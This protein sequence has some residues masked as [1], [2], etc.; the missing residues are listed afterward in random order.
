MG[1]GAWEKMSVEELEAEV[2]RHNRLYF[3]KHVREI[4]DYEF[5]RLVEELK[6]R[7]PDSPVLKEI[8][9]DV[10]EIKGQL[11]L[12]S[13]TKIP[14]S[15]RHEQPMLSLD[16]CYDEN[17]I[18]DWVS[19]IL[20]SIIASPKIDGCAVS[21]KYDEDG[22]LVQAV[23]RGDGVE[24]EDI[25]ENIKEISSIPK[26]VNMKNVEVRG[27]VYMPLSV[28][29]RYQQ[30]FA[31]P[32][33]LAAG[34]IK[35]KDPKK[36]G[37]YKLKFLAY[38]LLRTK[39]QT[40]I[41][42]RKALTNNKFHVVDTVLINSDELQ[43]AYED[44]LNKRNKNDFETDGVVF[45]ANHVSEQTRLGSTAH[46]PKWAIAYKYQGESGATRLVNVVWSVARTGVIT[47]VAIVKPVKLSGATVTRASLHNVG[48]LNKLGVGIDDKI[49]MM[50]RGGVI[51]NVEEVVQHGGRPVAIPKTCPSCGAPTE[52][53]EDSL[54]C[55]NPKKCVQK[56]IGEL[57]HFVKTAG[58]DGFG[59]KLLA[60]LYE[61][62]I[63][64]DPSELYE[65]TKDELLGLERMGDTLAEKLLANVAAKKRMPLGAFLQGLGI[66]ELGKHAAG[67][68]EKYGSLEKVMSLTEDELSEIHTFGEVIAHEVVLGLKAKRRLIDR[69]LKH[70][71]VAKSAAKVQRGS[72]AGKSFLFTGSLE[73][74]ERS[75]AQ[76]LVEEKGGDAAQSVTKTLDYLVVGAEGGAGS[77]LDKAK[78]LAAAGGK[79]KIISEDDFL[80]M[81]RS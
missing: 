38:D 16:K 5:D 6:R 11:E 46:H 45:K 66:R 42:K 62:G 50:R 73:S 78:K 63:V 12:W 51:P 65:I 2:S 26:T 64:T 59:E 40:E 20:G 25:T 3:V 30:D 48:I 77:K 47:P 31:N 81:I 9:S 74:M 39:V 56:K 4:E 17:T 54:Y 28:F 68:L 61:S 8:P 23:T 34:A 49:V 36:T 75:E 60:R 19:K 13:G 7:K 72:L 29:K 14:T 44:F 67:I 10:P 69:L 15:V 18:S 57:S 35:Q 41:E 21:I 33:N 52:L 76:K 32:R 71:T 37:E 80:R 58:I 79:V 24:G 27:E 70:V 53:R 55:T 22:K 1:K 43:K